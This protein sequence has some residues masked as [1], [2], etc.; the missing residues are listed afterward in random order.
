MVFYIWVEL[1]ES[2]TFTTF[3]AAEE[4][5]SLWGKEIC[6]NNAIVEKKLLTVSL[7]NMQRHFNNLE[8]KRLPIFTACFCFSGWRI[9]NNKMFTLWA[10]PV[11]EP[12]CNFI[13]SLY[14]LHCSFKTFAISCVVANCLA[15][16]KSCL[17]RWS[18][19]LPFTVYT[20]SA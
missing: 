11:L 10:E 15:R 5:I 1:G 16:L 19:L 20:S 2:Y 13:Y 17:I 8:Q 7:M 4:L 18:V 9:V 14:L 3:M 6:K 12:G